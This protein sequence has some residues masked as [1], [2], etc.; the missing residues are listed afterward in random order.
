MTRKDSNKRVENF[1]RGN[2]M[3]G[4]RGQDMQAAAA[5]MWG[6]AVQGAAVEKAAKS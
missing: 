5:I 3:G 2:A 4:R 1:N 6:G